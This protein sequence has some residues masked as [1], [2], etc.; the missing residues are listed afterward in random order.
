MRSFSPTPISVGSILLKSIETN[1][2]FDYAF[3]KPG[4]AK[5]GFG[6]SEVKETEDG[7]IVASECSIE[8]SNNDDEV[9]ATIK[10]HFIVEF[11]ADE[12]FEE[13]TSSLERTVSVQLAA[14]E[15]AYPYHRLTV[16]NLTD[17]FD[18]PAYRLPFAF[19]RD[20]FAEGVAA[21]EDEDSESADSS[22]A[23]EHE[24]F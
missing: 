7:M 3:A 6:I 20:I 14:T 21:L 13:L 10:T 12:T 1:R 2:D 4:S 19:D 22:A 17:L 23:S 9:V 5:L 24:A 16:V 8:L 18:I 11:T 15:A